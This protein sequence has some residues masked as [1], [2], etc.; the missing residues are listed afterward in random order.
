MDGTRGHDCGDGASQSA[1]QWN[2]GATTQTEVLQQT[3]PQEP[4]TSH[5]SRGFHRAGQSKKN[6]DLRNENDNS[7]DSTENT[8]EQQIVALHGR[9]RDLADSLLDGGEV[10]GKLDADALLQL[11]KGEA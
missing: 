10:S 4:D 7:R 11:L 8:I 5:V 9:K 1:N 6:H 2:N 3:I